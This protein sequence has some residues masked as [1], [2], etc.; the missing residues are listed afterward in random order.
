M[1]E[2]D[3]PERPA[4]ALCNQQRATLAHATASRVLLHAGRAAITG[5]WA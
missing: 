1:S 2:N 5:I 3:V 4:R